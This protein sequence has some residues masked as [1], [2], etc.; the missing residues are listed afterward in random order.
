MK[1]F[2]WLVLGLVLSINVHG[3]DYIV[4]KLVSQGT[5]LYNIGK[6][7]E[8]ITKYKAAL[9]IDDNATVANYELSYTY[10]ADEQYGNA[11][12]YSKKV[13]NQKGSNLQDAYVVL[14]YSL[15]KTGKSE[16]AIKTLEEGLLKYPD[17][18]LLNYNLALASYSLKKY[19]KA[20]KA[21]INA[22][23]ART[24]HG[25]SQM[26]LASIMQ[27]KGQRVKTLLPLY[28]FL[29]LEPNSLRS[30]TYYDCLVEQLNLG[31]V[32]KDK[33]E[34]YVNMPYST[35]DYD[36]GASDIMV[37]FIAASKH[38]KENKNKSNMDYFIETNKEFFS[39]L[40]ESKKKNNGFWWDIYVTKFYDLVQSN[41]YEAFSYYISQSS[42]S[43]T[44][45]KW[46]AENKD[47]MTKFME[48]LN[49]R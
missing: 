16:K 28:Y 22:V 45:N 49:N 35:S 31:V 13:I 19:D 27:A 9:E 21:A 41:N 1:L 5:E 7:D 12:K 37:S 10:M 48:W 20:E 2:I 3:Q 6:Y 46:I 36:F 26:I 30:K 34:I 23:K 29:M 42:N 24:N 11:I 40:G 44:V 38:L 4:N 32:K 14:G 15:Y 33:N 39:N 8:A 25:S 18:N 17:N 43:E 47:K